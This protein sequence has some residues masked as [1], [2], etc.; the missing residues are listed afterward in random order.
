ML[1]GEQHGSPSL[2]NAVAGKN[3]KV[4]GVSLVGDCGTAEEQLD[5]GGLQPPVQLEIFVAVDREG[6]L[7]PPNLEQHGPRDGEITAVKVAKL[8]SVTGCVQS[9]EMTIEL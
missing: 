1:R 7:E 2:G 5:A 3:T 6:F 4:L 8:E 9:V